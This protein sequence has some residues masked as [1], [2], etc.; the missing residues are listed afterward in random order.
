MSVSAVFLVDTNVLVY[1]YDPRAQIKQMRAIEVLDCLIRDQ[2]AVLSVQ[3]LSEFFNVVRRRLP[4]PMTG[5]EALVRVERLSRVCRVLD[6]TPGVVL[7]LL[8]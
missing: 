3:C 5:D 6:L 2:R 4:E 7:V 1:L 8:R